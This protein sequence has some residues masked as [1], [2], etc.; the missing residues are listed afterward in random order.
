MSD[1][2]RTVL[3]EVA[4]DVDGVTWGD[5]A[6]RSWALARRRRRRRTVGA[7]A[8]V[9]GIALV[10]PWTRTQLQPPAGTAAG[11]SPSMTAITAGPSGSTPRSVN[12]V[13]IDLLDLTKLDL[14]KTD[15]TRW[16]V[17][18]DGSPLPPKLFVDWDQAVPPLGAGRGTAGRIGAVVLRQ[19]DAKTFRPVF[20]LGGSMGGLVEAA[21]V[22]L[23]LVGDPVNGGKVPLGA[24]VVSPDGY[25][26][27]FVQDGAVVFVDV[28]DGS[29]RRVPV[30]TT[31]LE[32]GG[33]SAGGTWFI[34]HSHTAHW[35]IDPAAPGGPIVRR[36]AEVVQEGRSLMTSDG[37]TVE[38]LR[39][40]DQGTLMSQRALNPVLGSTWLDTVTSAG[41]LAA[42]GS[43]F[44][45]EVS[46]VVD[47]NQG[48]AI[49]GIDTGS[50]SES[51][52]ILVLQGQPD[53]W[54]GAFAA[55]G[56]ISEDVVLYRL[57]TSDE[58]RLMAWDIARGRSWIVAQLQPTDHAAGLVAL[59]VGLQVVPE[60]PA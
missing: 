6:Q 3:T 58:V 44:G 41:G 56:W 18:A 17:A 38:L 20:F 29:V 46:S 54:K 15:G 23:S 55:L 16:V 47:G 53:A 19:V 7:V 42:T 11:N 28:R 48:L 43:M 49:A 1:E 25:R 22:T 14:T 9:A 57:T 37:H 26:V 24:H 59:G 2:L 39:F 12:G 4:G 35:R 45:A 34:A 21:T 32:V 8:V 5:S 40:D 36:A 52:R 33:W 31:Y 50:S 30:P 13:Q 27:G 60:P 10:L 51:P